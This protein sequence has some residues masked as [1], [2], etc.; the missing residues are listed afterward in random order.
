MHQKHLICFKC[1]KRFGINDIVFRCDECGSSLEVGF[2]YHKI[3]KNVTKEK[4]RSR[5]FNHA[6]YSELYPVPEIL[7]IQEGGTPLIR[8]KRIEKELKLGFELW[9]KYE[10]Q[11]PTGSFKDRGSSVELARAL[12]IIRNKGNPFKGVVCASTGNMGASVAAYS[13]MANLK[14]TIFTPRDAVDIKLEQ[15][16]AYGAKVYKINGDYTQAAELVEQAFQKHGVYLLG[17]YL[18]RREGTKSVGFEIADQ[19]DFQVPDYVVCPIGNGTL[20]SAVWKAF[21]EFKILGLTKNMPHMI[22]IQAKGCDPVNKAF[23]KNSKIKH[24][25]GSTIATAIECGDPLD[26][27]RALVVM[28]ESDGFTDNISDATILKTRELLAKSEG[29]F[30]EPAGAVSFAGLLAIKNKIPKG[31]RVVCLLTGHGLKTPRTAIKG[32]VKKISASPKI[33]SNIF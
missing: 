21:N 17:D 20:I 16:L 28:K 18:Y 33:L 5:P 19:M 14:C 3:K 7:S 8:S 6:R 25:C 32:S 30:T 22:G 31:S 13:S 1:G 10:A 29:L 26:G 9:F 15:I 11:N 2:D 23:N 4:L 12:D 27:P 24:V